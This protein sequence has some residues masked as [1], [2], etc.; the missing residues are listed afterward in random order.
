MQDIRSD[1]PG[2]SGVVIK[3]HI[4]ILQEKNIFQ[5]KIQVAQLPL[6]VQYFVNY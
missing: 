4:N 5:G 2:R 3:D 6:E 1:N